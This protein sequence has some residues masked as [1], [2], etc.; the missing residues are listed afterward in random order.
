MVYLEFQ[1]HPD[2]EEEFFVAEQLGMTVARLRAEMGNDEYVRWLVYF[3][4]RGQRDQ[5]TG[6]R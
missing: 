2:M 6:G 1:A 3:G 5:I 4:R